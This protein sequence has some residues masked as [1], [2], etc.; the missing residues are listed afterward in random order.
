METLLKFLDKIAGLQMD[1]FCHVT[2]PNRPGQ[3][4]LNIPAHLIW[5]IILQ[6]VKEPL[7]IDPL[8]EHRQ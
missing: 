1:R 2:H 8:Q 3:M 7:R 4:L 6:M 5:K